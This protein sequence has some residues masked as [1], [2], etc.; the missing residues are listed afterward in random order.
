MLEFQLVLTRAVQVFDL[1]PGLA[2][3]VRNI[4]TTY[5]TARAIRARGNYVVY[6]STLVPVTLE[7]IIH[8]VAHIVA[9]ERPDLGGHGHNMEYMCILQELTEELTK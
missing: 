6:F 8:E 7:S 4:P 9:W 1:N 3:G 2:V 5:F